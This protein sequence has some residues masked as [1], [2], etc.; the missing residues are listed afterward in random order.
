MG[1]NGIT[2]GQR[3]KRMGQRIGASTCPCPTSGR[4][5]GLGYMD[6]RCSFRHPFSRFFQHPSTYS[7]YF[8]YF[9]LHMPQSF[10]PIL[11]LWIQ[12]DST[13]PS[14]QPSVMLLRSFSR[15]SS[16]CRSLATRKN[17]LRWWVFSTLR[18]EHRTLSSV[19]FLRFSEFLISISTRHPQKSSVSAPGHLLTQGTL[20]TSPCHRDAKLHLLHLLN[21]WIIFL[22]TSMICYD[23]LC[24]NFVYIP[25]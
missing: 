3:M 15:F 2:M 22:V 19:N 23:T 11:S 5:C 24:L 8:N 14:P 6:W 25:L 18:T 10:S 4:W 21:L 17:L 20:S 12:H 9:K 13:I 1:F 7:N 16:G